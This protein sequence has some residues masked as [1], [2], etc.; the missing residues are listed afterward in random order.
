MLQKRFAEQMERK[1]MLI[2]KEIMEHLNENGISG[3]GL[4]PNIEVW[5]E[6]KE[7]MKEVRDVFKGR[8][9]EWKEKLV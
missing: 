7:G 5:D 8:F 6:W 9:A 2:R 4:E 3:D 1:E